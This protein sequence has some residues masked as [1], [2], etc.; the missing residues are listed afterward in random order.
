MSIKS[1][2]KALDSA[3]DDLTSLH[4]QTYTGKIN[5]AE[6]WKEAPKDT[7]AEP[8]TLTS[9]K[10]FEGFSDQLAANANVSLVADTLIKFDGDSYNFIAEDATST[11]SA[12]ALHKDA[13]EAGINTRLGL[14]ELV[15]DV[16]K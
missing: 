9:K 14:M 4:V 6:A 12:L 3:I 13:V 2:L 1:T 5:W 11:E 10:T 16:F 8:Q 7:D 15:R